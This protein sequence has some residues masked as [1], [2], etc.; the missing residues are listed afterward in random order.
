MK[1][2]R[3]AFGRRIKLL[4]KNRRMTQEK[5]AEIVGLNPRQLTR[6][7]TGENFPSSDTLVKLSMALD[8][9]V[10]YMFDFDWDPEIAMLATGTDAKPVLRLVQNNEVVTIKSYSP[11]IEDKKKKSKH[12]PVTQSEE[13]MKKIAKQINKPL[14]VEYFV[15]KT[16][17]NIKTYYPNGKV[18]DLLTEIDIRENEEYKELCAQLKKFSKSPAKLEF[19]KLALQ[20]FDNKDAAEKLKL[21]LKGMDLNN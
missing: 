2:F 7:E 5:L 11:V 1:E 19:F 9:E 18:E 10:K 16:R 21:M 15:N 17:A 12:F 3:E 4:R 20:V 8:L 13:S 14:T 6:I